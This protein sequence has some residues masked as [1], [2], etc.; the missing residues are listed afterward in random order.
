MIWTHR[1]AVMW[2]F[3]SPEK[4]H[5]C[6]KN[7][8][9]IFFF[10]FSFLYCDDLA[11]WNKGKQNKSK[12]QNKEEISCILSPSLSSSTVPAQKIMP[13]IRI[14]P[15]SRSETHTCEL[16]GFTETIGE[17]RWTGEE[18][19]EGWFCSSRSTIWASATGLRGSHR[20]APA[21]SPPTRW[22]T[23]GPACSI[24]F[25]HPSIKVWFNR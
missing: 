16:G 20:S 25:S 9:L 14:V 3:R 1:P 19:P 15:D 18:G 11:L 21:S 12:K 6:P 17:R 10:S 2:L 24:H 4:G 5:F 22:L 13:S 23:W 8:G 7:S